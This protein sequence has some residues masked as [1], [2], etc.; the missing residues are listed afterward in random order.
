FQATFLVLVRK[1]GSIRPQGLVSNWLY[2][3]AHQVA[4]KAYAMNAKKMSR[5]KPLHGDVRAKQ[6]SWHEL[7]AVLDQE[8]SRL[9]EK[10]RA[11]IVLCDLEGKTR[12]EAAHCLGVPE[13]TVAGRTA[14]AR[15][16]LAKRL[17]RHGFAVSGGALAAL[18][19]QGA[20]SASAPAAV[21]ASAIKSANVLAAGGAVAAN[22]AAL[23]E[24]VLKTMLLTKLKL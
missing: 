20:A 16:M 5:E 2:G 1:A 10:Y 11:T 21:V 6:D 7:Q 8:L 23:T 9:P 4:V 18:L 3:V 14:R 17:A 24:G 22:A 15:A 13:G 19:S 12:K